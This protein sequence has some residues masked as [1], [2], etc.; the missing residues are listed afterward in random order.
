[1]VIGQEQDV[2]GGRF[3]QSESFMGKMAYIDM[4]SKILSFSD[5]LD[6]FND[7]NERIFGNL[8][9][10]PQMQEYIEGG[11]QVSFYS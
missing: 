2:M 7:C 10:W 9:G 5:I 6:H 8:Y 4:W 11:I 3:S 1:M